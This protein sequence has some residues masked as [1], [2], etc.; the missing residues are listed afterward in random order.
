ME[1]TSTL[2]RKGFGLKK[3]VQEAL[4]GDYH[5]DLIKQI[6]ESGNVLS[7]GRVTVKLAKEF[8]FCYGVDK[9]VDFAY[10]TRRQF[11]DKRIFLTTEIIHNPMVNHRLGEMGIRFLTGQYRAE[12]GFTDIM[13]QDVVILPAFGTTVEEL[14]E[15][16]TKNCVLVDTT[17]GSVI[18][19]WMRVEKYAKNGFTAVIHG[20]YSHEETKG[21]S[22]RALKYPG[23]R[24]LIV[25]D[26]P[27]AQRV[28]DF[29]LT[30]QGREALLEEFAPAMSPGFDPDK[31]LQRVGLANQTTMLSSES[32]EI[33][34]MFQAAMEQKFGQDK[35]AEH[36]QNFDTICSATQDRQDAVLDLLKNGVDRMIVIGGYNSS[37]TGHLCEIASEVVP[38]YHIQD[39]K[40]ILSAQQISHRHPVSHEILVSGDWLPLQ[41]PQTIGVTAGASTPN[42]VIAEVIEKIFSAQ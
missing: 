14:E 9:A 37:N 2:Y 33:A 18:N 13:P 24:Y 17:C 27:Q 30:G 26:K 5:S 21:T 39:A 4:A 8:G 23:G 6:R 40:D 36:F 10:E 19:V 32:L 15:L 22:S 38:T 41:R 20:K 3:E 1:P 7:R 35:L 16:K 29:I 25:R 28:I 11:P 42:R 12:H 31:D 34:Q